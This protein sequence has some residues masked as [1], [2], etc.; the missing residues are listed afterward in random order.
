MGLVLAIEKLTSRASRVEATGGKIRQISPSFGGKTKSQNG[1]WGFTSNL[2]GNVFKAI[3]SSIQWSFSAL[4]GAVVSATQAIWNFDWNVSDK[5][6]DDDIQTSLKG[7]TSSLG[8]TLGAAAGYTACGALPGAVIMSFNEPLGQYVLEQLGEEALAEM[9]GHLTNLVQASFNTVRVSAFGFLYKN[10]R[11]LWRTSDADFLKG[12]KKKGFKG[13]QLDRALQERNKPWSFALK[14]QEKI[15]AI[16][17]ELVKSFVESFTEQFAS[18]CIEAG[19]VIAG[20]ID[21]FYIQQ[22]LA[23]DEQVIEVDFNG[24]NTPQVKTIS[25]TALA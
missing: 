22:K 5:Q 4:W 13:A 23:T 25:A 2:I 20:S 9:T 15:E 3:T 17:N 10:V 16:P 1:F 19:Y 11:H 18:S 8:N 6:L 21:S 12:L 24:G 14:A 7:L